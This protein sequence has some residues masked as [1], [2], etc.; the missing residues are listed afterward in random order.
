MGSFIQ[1]RRTALA[2]AGLLILSAIFALSRMPGGIGGTGISG[3]PGGIGGTGIYGRIDAF[4]SIWVNGVEIFYD[5]EQNVIRQGRDG[6]PSRLKIGQIVAVLVDEE[7]NRVFANSIEI[8]EEVNGPVISVAPDQLEVMGQRVIMT[9]DTIIDIPGGEIDSNRQ[10]AVSGF[11][12][13][14]GDIIASHI[15]LP[16]IAN[17]MSLRGPIERAEPN[18][19]WIEDQKVI[20]ENHG[21]KNGEHVEI[22][23]ILDIQGDGELNL[24]V[25]KVRERGPL[26]FDKMPDMV[27]YQLLM[28]GRDRITINQEQ[29]TI[30]Q[31]DVSKV[32]N[33]GLGVSKIVTIKARAELLDNKI[34]LREVQLDEVRAVRTE[35]ISAIMENRRQ[36]QADLVRQ[37]ELE[38]RRQAEIVARRQAELEA[39]RQSE[40]E[41][42]RQTE[43][44]ARRKAELDARRQAEL[45]AR[46]QAELEA[47]RQAGIEAR[48]QAAA[49]ARRQAEFEARRQAEIEAR[50]QAE[51]EARRQ[52]E[53]EARIQAELE[54]RE[55]AEMQIKNDIAADIKD[56]AQG[57]LKDTARIEVR[58]Q[59]RERLR[60]EA[61]RRARR[62]HR[63][64]NLQ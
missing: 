64:N 57:D 31:V 49:L 35:R 10:I 8:I 4:G 59:V 27:S 28:D 15:A 3:A 32:E 51:L 29:I 43:Q 60:E 62:D 56:Q 54:A 26:P 25:N 46:R 39:R 52:A 36:E 50:R 42:H 33:L 61:R 23:G 53:F 34:S 44:Q 24:I 37:S 58:H 55:Q 21:L 11:R 38:I 22:S 9:D 63:I 40:I 18:S 13:P 17:E 14:G 47:R 6:L 5:A 41:A 7:G 1:N 20:Q 19:Y 12:K 30:P 16:L 48:R 2:F 45:E